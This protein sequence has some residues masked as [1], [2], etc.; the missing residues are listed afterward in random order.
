MALDWQKGSAAIILRYTWY[1]D[2]SGMKKYGSLKAM[3]EGLR[4]CH[5]LRIH[6]SYLVNQEYIKE[7]GVREVYL[8]D[9]TVIEMGRDRKKPDREAMRRYDWVRRAG[10]FF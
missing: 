5:F 1:S 7:V 8:T 2:G 6:K 4:G 9:G 10:R 3:E